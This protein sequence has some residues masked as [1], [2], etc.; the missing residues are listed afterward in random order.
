MQT[1][2]KFFFVTVKLM[3][4]IFSAVSVCSNPY[5]GPFPRTNMSFF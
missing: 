4:H 2:T 5:V 1:Q 3:E